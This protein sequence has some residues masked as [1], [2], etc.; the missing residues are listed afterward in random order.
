VPRPIVR[1]AGRFACLSAVVYAAVALA[2]APSSKPDA[3]DVDA[4]IA[5]LAGDDWAARQ[6]AQ[7][8]LIARGESIAP[9]L[10]KVA[11]THSDREVRSRAAAA[12]ARIEHNRVLGRT[13]ITLHMTDVPAGQAFAELARQARAPIPTEPS[14]LFNQKSVKRVSLNVDREPFWSVMQSLCAQSELEVTQIT[15]GG[16]EVMG[17]ARGTSDWMDKPTTLAGPLLIRADRLVRTSSV[18]LKAPRQV[19]GDFNISFTVFAEPKLK[20]LDF[21]SSVHVDKVTDDR[22]NSLLPP[23]N[24]DLAANVDV[25]GNAH[26]AGTS[27]WEVGATLHQPKGAGTT[28]VQFKGRTALLVQ[29]DSAVLEVPVSKAK[30]AAQSVGGLRITVKSVDASRAELSVVRDGREDAEWYAVRMQLSAG[31]A[32]LLNEQGQVVARH[33][34]GVDIDDTVG[35]AGQRMDVKFRFAREPADDGSKD[36]GSRK[37]GGAGASHKAEPVTFQFHFPTETMELSVPF[38]FRDLPIP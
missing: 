23:A 38:E 32:R 1:L 24:A 30:N 17:L 36:G 18:R 7:D 25:F 16:R 19:T 2:D 4:D 9:Q 33:Q 15:R 10:M 28:I 37:D 35:A 6:A 14:N 8:R 11:T 5:Q 13:L 27:N 21:S 29:T 22:G 12:V 34:N 3:P 31:E 20:V 26:E